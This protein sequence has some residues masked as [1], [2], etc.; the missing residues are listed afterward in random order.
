[1]NDF[2]RIAIYVIAALAIAGIVYVAANVAGIGI[3]GWVITIFWI[4]LAAVACIFAVKLI[5]KAA[6]S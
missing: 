1:M 6:N 3:P 2:A 5:M 4:I